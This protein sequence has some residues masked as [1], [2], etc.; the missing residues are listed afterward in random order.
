MSCWLYLNNIF[1][2][3]DNSLHSKDGHRIFLIT[4]CKE[5]KIDSEACCEYEDD[6]S[7]QTCIE[8]SD[9]R[10]HDPLLRRFF[11]LYLWRLKIFHYHLRNRVKFYYSWKLCTAW[12][13]RTFERI[14]NA[15]TQTWSLSNALMWS[16]V[17][18]D[19]LR[20]PCRQNI[21]ES[22]RAVSGR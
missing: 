7:S 9:P 22:T 18:M 11:I 16:S 4:L 17:S 14:M 3:C 6:F 8:K 15:S 12:V 21:C 19:G 20:P 2:H 1:I 13:N 5:W 10:F